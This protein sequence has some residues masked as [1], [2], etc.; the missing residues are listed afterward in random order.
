MFIIN[1]LLNTR[2][3]SGDRSDRG[4]NK[5]DVYIQS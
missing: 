4:T 5:Y 3:L 2:F 1:S